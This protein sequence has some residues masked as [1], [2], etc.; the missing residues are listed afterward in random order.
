MTRFRRL[1]KL[2]LTLISAS[3]MG[4]GGV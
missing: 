3:G 4:S 2:L 1:A